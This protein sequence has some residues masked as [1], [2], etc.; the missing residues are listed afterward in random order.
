MA[1]NVWLTQAEMEGLLDKYPAEAL[2]DA[3]ERLSDYSTD[4]NIG[5]KTRKPGWKRFREYTDHVRA[6]RSFLR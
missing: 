1:P 2:D 6:L 4:P 3:L 5:L